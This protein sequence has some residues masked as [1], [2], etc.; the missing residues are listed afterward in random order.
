MSNVPE[1]S[2]AVLGDPGPQGSKRHVGGGRMIEQSKKVAPWR[3]SVAWAARQAMGARKP[4][5]GPLRCEI[6]YTLAKPRSAPKRRRTWPNRKPDGDKLDRST[7][8]AMTTA[9]VWRDDAQ[10]VEW[11]GA[12]RYPGEGPD[13]LPSIGAVVRVWRIIEHV[14]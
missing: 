3:D 10:V 6:V 7:H 13:A 9:G 2:F 4:L 11:T 12:K 14:P 1:V 8:D 5:E